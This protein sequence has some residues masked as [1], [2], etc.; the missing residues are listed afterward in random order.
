MA[1]FKQKR[2]FKE[3]LNGSTITKAMKVAG[4]ADT[5][6]STTGKLTNTIGWN[7]LMNEYLPDKL[8]AKKH[9]EGLEA[10]K[11]GESEEP[12]YAVRHK[13]LDSAY[14]VKGNYAPEKKDI[15]TG[16]D[17]LSTNKEQADML[18]TSYLESI[19]KKD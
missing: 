13:Y 6:A 2:A 19:I 11:G 14:K 4:Y 9:L 12:D 3:V 15:T 17:K 16:G 7:E 18:I 1:T 8:L 10:T 5:T